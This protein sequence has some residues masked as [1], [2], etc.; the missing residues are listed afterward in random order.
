MSQNIEQL[1]SRYPKTRPALSPK[2]QAVYE[3]EYLLN[4]GNDGGFLYELIEKLESWSHKKIAEQK[5]PSPILELGPGTLNQVPFESEG[6]DYDIVEPSDF[7]YRDSPHLPRLRNIYQAIE[8]VPADAEPYQ[9]ILSKGVLEHVGDLPDMIARCALL[10]ADDGLFQNS[11]PAEGGFL[12]GSS[13]RL[14]TGLA[15]RLR[16]GLDYGTVMRHEHINSAQ[17][18]IA[19]IRYFFED[20]TLEYFPL[21]SIHL[22]FYIYVEAKKPKRSVAK[23]YLAS[24]GQAAESKNS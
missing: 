20:V 9:R 14:T 21:P 12:W 2:H 18:M 4:R 8:E 3:Q 10:L 7:F 6:Y 11:I 15:Y 1:L 19:L 13:W 16:T 5:G 24:Q 23:A 17:E 22:S